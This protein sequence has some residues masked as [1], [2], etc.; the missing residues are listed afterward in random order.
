[1]N[2]ITPYLFGESIIRSLTIDAEPWFVAKDVCDCL[3]ITNYRQAV[4]GNSRSGALGLEDDEKGVY[5]LDTLGGPQETVIVNES[6][7]YALIFKSRKAEAR[8]FRKWVTSEVLPTIRR[9]GSYGRAHTVFL[10]LIK[11]QIALGVSPD[12][13]ARLAGKL[14]GEPHEAIPSR[15]DAEI[16]FLLSL[17]KP[18]ISYTVPELSD[19][20][21]ADHPNR[22]DSISSRNSRIGKILMKAVTHQ[23]LEKIYGRNN[24]FRLPAI[25]TFPA[26]NS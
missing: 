25:T 11:D 3:G 10:G 24:R 6:G 19:L 4:A 8:R 7:L 9:T 14:T 22:Q 16:N 20:L 17:M 12:L 13:A 21:P 15:Q 5:I 23:R 18:G 26:S 2:P 1:M